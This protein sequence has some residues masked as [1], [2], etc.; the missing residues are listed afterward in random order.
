MNQQL[1]E[2]VPSGRSGTKELSSPWSSGPSMVA[3]GS[4]LLPQPAR[5]PKPLLWGRL[6][7]IGMID[8]ITGQ[9]RL[10]Q[11]SAPLSFLEIR[12]GAKRSSALLMAGSPGSQSPKS[13]HSLR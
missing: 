1:D 5:S 6:H 10:I 12:G 2:E 13:P 9:S 11:P 8:E 3:P 7:D 4:I